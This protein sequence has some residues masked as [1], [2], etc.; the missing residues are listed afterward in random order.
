MHSK[1]VHEKVLES[2]P[3]EYST[4]PVG[5]WKRRVCM[6]SGGDG[7]CIFGAARPRLK[8]GTAL[9]MARLGNGIF[10]GDYRSFRL[11]FV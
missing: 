7:A 8:F 1:V 4:T 3:R 2:S 5:G 10:P 6:A 11:G 9:P